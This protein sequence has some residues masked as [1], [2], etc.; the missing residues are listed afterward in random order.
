MM[1][2][3]QELEAQVTAQAA[4]VQAATAQSATITASA[5]RKEPKIAGPK[6]FSGKRTE[7]QEFILKCETVFSAQAVTYIDDATKLAYAV[8]LLENEAY[9]W[10]KPALMAAESPSAINA[11]YVPVRRVSTTA[12]RR[13]T[14]VS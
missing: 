3:I 13:L 4:T 12:D 7:S 1:Q 5:T 14:G 11:S 10:I 9:E 2:R 8:N 6:A